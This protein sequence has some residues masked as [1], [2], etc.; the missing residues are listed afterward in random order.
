MTNAERPSFNIR[1]LILKKLE[2]KNNSELDSL[3]SLSRK[4]EVDSLALKK[5][6]IKIITVENLIAAKTSND[7]TILEKCPKGIISI[8][9]PIF[10]RDFKKAVIDHSFAF[11]CIGGLIGTYEFKNDKWNRI[12][13]DL[14]AVEK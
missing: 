10:D 14:G 11:T 1:D 8:Q 3:V 6:G 2:L 9:K 4:F 7:Y 13:E 12:P 5:K